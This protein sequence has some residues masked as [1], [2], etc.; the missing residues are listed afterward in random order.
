MSETTL[1][2]SDPFLKQELEEIKQ[3]LLSIL[4]DV[5][6]VT[7]A[8]NRAILKEED[9]REQFRTLCSLIDHSFGENIEMIE[10]RKDDLK[11][12]DPSL[13]AIDCKLSTRM[14]RLRNVA[15]KPDLKSMKI[16][17]EKVLSQQRIEKFQTNPQQEEQRPQK[18]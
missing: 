11:E 1:E 2:E 18:G 4:A 8:M 16:E 9:R 5:E 15:I 10:K 17:M 13:Q 3:E 7:E 12:I 14:E 6:S